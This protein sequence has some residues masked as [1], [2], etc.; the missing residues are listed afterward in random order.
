MNHHQ[1][2]NAECGLVCLAY[3]SYKL[4]AY[5]DMAELR[6]KFPISNRGL[7]LRQIIEI[8]SAL[9]MLGRDIKCEVSEL[10]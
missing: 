4:G 1:T 2:E 3:A 5:L 10:A 7:T 6:R 9:D 8:A